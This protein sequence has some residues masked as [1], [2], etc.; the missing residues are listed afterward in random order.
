VAQRCVGDEK[1]LFNGSRNMEEDLSVVEQLQQWSHI[2]VH[3]SNGR[4]HVPREKQLV[5]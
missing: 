2:L 4:R 1:Q 5:E 3:Y